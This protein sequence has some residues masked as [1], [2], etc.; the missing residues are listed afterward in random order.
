MHEA[1][2]ARPSIEPPVLMDSCN[3]VDEPVAAVS[4]GGP[5]SPGA[6]AAI[7]GQACEEGEEEDAAQPG[8]STT[9]ADDGPSTSVCLVKSSSVFVILQ[10]FQL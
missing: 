7:C 2:G 6:G 8:S 9:Q 4:S 3:P 1:I 10:C 5:S